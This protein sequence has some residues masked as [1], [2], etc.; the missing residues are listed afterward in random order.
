MGIFELAHWSREDKKIYNYDNFSQRC[1]IDCQTQVTQISSK[2]ASKLK[3]RKGKGDRSKLPANYLKKT[4]KNPE[5]KGH[6]QLKNAFLQRKS[7][8]KRK[9]NS[10]NIY[11]QE[12]NRTEKNGKWQRKHLFSVGLIERVDLRL[13][14]YPFMVREI[15]VFV[16]TVHRL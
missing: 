16:A 2:W 13:R 7:F 11:G 12:I 1:K 6:L 5:I 8:T 3:P 10:R 9:A 4:V 15:I 14:G